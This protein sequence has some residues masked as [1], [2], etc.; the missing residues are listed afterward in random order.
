M[1]HLIIGTDWTA[2]RNEILRQVSQDVAQGFK[3]RVLMVPELISHDMERRLCEAAGD[4]ASRY[5]EVLSFTRLARRVSE[6]TQDPGFDCLDN[7]GRLVAMAAAVGSLHSKLKSYAAVETKPEFLIGL[8]DAVDEFKRCRISSADLKAGSEQAQGSLAQKL[9]ELSLILDAYDGLCANGKRD[10]RDRETQFLEQLEDSDFAQNHVFYIDGFP[11]FTRQHLAILCHLICYSPNV[12]ISVNCDHISSNAVAYEKTGQTAAE[13]TKCARNLGVECAV[14]VINGADSPLKSM[15]QKLFQGDIQVEPALEN[16][17]HVRYADSI[18]QECT[19]AAEQILALVQDGCR[20]RD[21]SVVCGDMGLY[22]DA[23]SM[24]FHR[25]GIPLYRS[26]TD[27]V[28]EMNVISAVLCA[29]DAALGGFDQQDMLRYMRSILSGLDMDLCDKVENYAIVWGICGQKWCSAWENHPDGLG[30]Q[31]T[32]SAKRRLAV[33]EDVRSK[34]VSPLQQLQRDFRGAKDLAGQVR[35]IY[36]FLEHTRLSRRLSDMAGKM[37]EEGDHR[38]AQILNQLWEILLCA[39]EQLHDVLGNTHWEDQNFVRL[40]TLL[41]SQYDVG[42]IPPVLDAVMC[43]PV[44]AMRCQEPK[45]LF[46]L[47]AEEGCL[48][49]YG[50]AAGVLNDQEREALRKLGLPLTGG[51]MEGIQVEFSEIYGVFCGARET[52]HI[53][54]ASGQ[55][56]FVWLRLETMAGKAT[57]ASG[58]Y[59]SA[60]TDIQDAG[61][62]LLRHGGQQEAELLGI[63]DHY[64]EAKSRISHQLGNISPEGVQ[65]LY[66]S[67]L[68]LSASQVD[69][70]GECRL[71]YFL[72]YGLRIKERK[73]VTIDPAEFGTYVH[74]V[75]EETAKAVMELG[76]FHQVPLEKTMELA[77]QFS[78]SYA[79]ERFSTLDS[80]R[81]TYLF[82]RNG[83]EL[84]LVIRELWKELSCT[85]FDPVDFETA[86]GDD[87]Q[88]PAIPIS[89]SAME[90]KLRG[91]VDRVDAWRENGQNYFRVVDYKTGRKDFDYC[92]VFNGIGLQMLL[93]LFALEQGGEAVLGPNPVS[94][95]V[96]Y[97]PAR[98]PLVSSEGRVTDAEAEQLHQKEWKRKGLLLHDEQVLRAM[99]PENAPK[100]I[101]ATW[102][103]DGTITGDLADREQMKLLQAYV[104]RILGRMVDDIASGN[105]QPNPY[106][107]G[108]SHNACAFCPYSPVCHPETV[109]GRRNYKTMDAQRFWDEIVREVEQN[110]R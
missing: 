51:A 41:L 91:F 62:F 42:T 24:I 35:A 75:L 31:W 106:T 38:S 19:E 13:L 4:T 57:R 74:A 25:C 107:R 53:S 50:G 68:N 84:E 49:G 66:G 88:L 40:L 59:G 92:D 32:D 58:R 89:G 98:V 102:K 63:T 20:F 100:R 15:S 55:P 44:S 109:E 29:L 18:F 90:A 94:A 101:C 65:T 47:G 82:R 16:R 93:Y 103:K 22:Q 77:K 28:L 36:R 86:F 69:R 34:L 45:H 81:L 61:A 26:G 76:G 1:L 104:F 79:E 39:L 14:T 33:L 9:E 64:Q 56:S 17:L 5:A 3:N 60:L 71:S 6:Y 21:I 70:Q 43:G 78:D 23:L 46:V 48:P 27:S 83:Q 11:D 7:G 73:E 105:V 85:H 37:D 8:V 95:G 12:T 110:G 97:F 30:E 96:Q 72:K 2:N 80:D 108:T 99:E 52:V 67:V 54:S 10:P 87:G